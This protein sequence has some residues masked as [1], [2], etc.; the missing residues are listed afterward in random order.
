WSSDVCSSDLEAAPPQTCEGPRPI[1]SGSFTCAAQLQPTPMSVHAEVVE[2]TDLGDRRAQLFESARAVEQVNTQHRPTAVAQRGGI[3][4]GLRPLELSDAVGEAGHQDVRARFGGDLEEHAVGST[5][6]VV[7]AG[8]M[9]VAG[10][11]TERRLDA[12]MGR[13]QGTQLGRVGIGEAIEV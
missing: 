12:G 7:L 10:S 6:L 2:G 5:A 1:R 4:G 9:Q 3:A 11:E 8:R 13:D